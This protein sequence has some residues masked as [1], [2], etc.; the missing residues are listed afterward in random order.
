VKLDTVHD[1]PRK[2]AAEKAAPVRV[3]I[4]NDH[5]GWGGA[6]HGVGRY[7]LNLTSRFDPARVAAIPVILRDEPELSK[8]FTARGIPLRCLGRSKNDPRALT[9]LVRL[10]RK[11]RIEVLHVQAL[12]ADTLGRIAGL[13]TGVP[14]VLHGRDRIAKRPISVR[15]LDRFLGPRTRYAL[16]VSE[17]VRQYLKRDRHIPL[18][19]IEVFYHGVDT[20]FFRPAAP[21]EREQERRE[22]GVPGDAIAVGTTT[23]LHPTK[24]H[25]HLVRAVAKLLPTEPNLRLLLANV[26]EEEHAL[27][28]EVARLDVADKVVF[29]GSRPDVRLFLAALDV[30][31]IPS[32]AEG[33]PNSMLEAMAM[34]RPVVSTNVDGMGEMLKP[35]ENALVVPAED[36]DALARELGRMVR[37][38]DLRERLSRASLA[39]ANVLSIRSTVERLTRIYTR[40]ARGT[41]AGAAV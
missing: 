18:D 9:D 26:G 19:N 13:W 38:P 30:F 31:A 11:E 20:D 12:K 36:A 40:L 41:P 22:L 25:V 10:L 16:A 33:F 39:F 17:T 35:G 21:E 27:R 15:L 23:R 32:L 2:H 24:G 14:T 37:E 8:V 1:S 4:A 3:L 6:F 34:G 5:L 29:A 7:L 28:E